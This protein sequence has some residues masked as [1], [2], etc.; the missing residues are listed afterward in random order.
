MRRAILLCLLAVASAA[1][2]AQAGE[3]A[4]QHVGV[5]MHPFWTGVTERDWNHELRIA[6]NSGATTVRID[7]SWATLE[8]RGKGLWDRRFAR[9]VDRFLAR[10]RAHRLKVIVVLLETPCWA[11]TAPTRLKQ[12]CRGAWWERGV[13]FYPPRQA[14]LYARAA[15]HVAERWGDDLLALEIWNEPN[16]DHFWRIENKAVHY[17]RLVRAS[18]RPVKQVA[19]DLEV[20]VGSLTLSDTEFL[21]DLYERGRIGGKYDAISYHPYTDGADPASDEVDPR[22]LEFSFRLGTA[23]LHDVMLAHGDPSPELW[24]T[25]AGAS[26]C[27]PAADDRCVDERTQARYVRAYVRGARDFPYVRA[28]LIYTLRDRGGERSDPLNYFGLVRRGFGAKPAL[29]AFRRALRG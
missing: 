28:M 9:R 16:I 20:L 22:G 1:A 14:G 2:P 23:A 6:R 29:H 25:E 5:Q 18:Y 12:G 10:A 8:L 27:N 13:T 3:P 11:S 21:T 17:S 26:S 24:A 7:V 15:R 4:E 19:P